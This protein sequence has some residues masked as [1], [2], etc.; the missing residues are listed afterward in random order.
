M[1]LVVLSL[2]F[3]NYCVHCAL[4]QSFNSV[5]R[6]DGYIGV[7]GESYRY[8]RRDEPELFFLRIFVVVLVTMRVACVCEL[9]VTVTVH[10]GAQC[11]V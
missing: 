8:T 2:L 4:P 9:T 11:A 5:C 7:G 6:V 10:S 3:V 1:S